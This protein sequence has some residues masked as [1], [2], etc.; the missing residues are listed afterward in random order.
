MTETDYAADPYAT[1][2]TVTTDYAAEEVAAP[3]EEAKNPTMLYFVWGILHIWM[4]VLGM[5]IYNWYPGLINSNAW[6]KLQCPTTAWTAATAI[7]TV[8]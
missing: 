3:E 8:V 4:A 2:D 5:L 6:W 7:T 1:D